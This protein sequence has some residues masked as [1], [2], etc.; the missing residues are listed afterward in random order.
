MTEKRPRPGSAVLVMHEGK[1]LLG[2]RNKVNANNKWVLPGGGIDWGETSE[3][4]A[5][6]EAL[7][8][9]G[10][11]VELEELVCVK[12]IIATHA[13]YHSI[14]FFYKAKPKKPEIK[15][16]DDLS[17]AKFFTI[18]EIKALDYVQSVEDVLKEAGLWD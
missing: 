13:D 8:E 1:I 5:K 15:V 10:L 9:T 3:E 4:A 14:V 6:R 2:R 16:S 11:E 18:Q 12:E 7:E 17:E